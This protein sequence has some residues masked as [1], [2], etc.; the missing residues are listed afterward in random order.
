MKEWQ[1]LRNERLAILKERED[2]ENEKKAFKQSMSSPNDI[3]TQKI[4]A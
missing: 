1:K 4:N 3:W 2:F